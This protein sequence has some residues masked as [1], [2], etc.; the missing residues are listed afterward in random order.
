[1]RSTLSFALSFVLIAIGAGPRDAAGQAPNDLPIVSSYDGGNPQEDG[2][3]VGNRGGQVQ[4]D[5]ASGEVAFVFPAGMG[6]TGVGWFSNDD[7]DGARTMEIEFDLYVSQSFVGHQSRENK[8]VWLRGNTRSGNQ[9][10]PG[11]VT[12]RGSG[13]GSLTLQIV[14]QYPGLGQS[15]LGNH[16][17][18]RGR[19]YN[20]RVR[21]DVDGSARAW[22]DGALAIDVTHQWTNDGP[23]TWR[24][25]DWQPW[26]GGQGQTVPRDMEI[27]GRNFV[28]RGR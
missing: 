25:A 3:A 13:S 4:V 15:H 19:W 23:F 27:R 8:V 10:A 12:L 5:E 22:V 7:I 17:I 2:W 28:V 16:P 14:R 24:E 1:M 20:I 18:Q 21:V 9:G 6:S 11:F 26:Y